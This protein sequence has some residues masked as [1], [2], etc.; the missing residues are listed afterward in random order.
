MECV[1]CLSLAFFT[2]MIKE[3]IEFKIEGINFKFILI[4]IISRMSRD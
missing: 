2:K 3:K 1:W 4:F